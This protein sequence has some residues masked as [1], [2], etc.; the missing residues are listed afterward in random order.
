MS[1]GPENSES[2]RKH[3]H[4][5]N[6]RYI[7]RDKLCMLTQKP[8]ASSTERERDLADV[9]YILTKHPDQI[10]SISW[11]PIYLRKNFINCYDAIS[12][13]DLMTDYFAKALWLPEEEV[14]VGDYLWDRWTNGKSGE[15]SKPVPEDN[16]KGSSSF[17]TRFFRRWRAA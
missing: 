13:N 11:I 16:G 5:L 15:S 14:G 6:L 9:A 17:W 8:P 12:P 2:Q 10:G 1:L 4:C 7:L 3:Y